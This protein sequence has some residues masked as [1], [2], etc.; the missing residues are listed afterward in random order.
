MKSIAIIGYKPHELNIF[1]EQDQKITVIQE[2]IK[3]QLVPLVEQELEW[4]VISG[5]PGVEM[6]AF[7]VVEQLKNDYDLKIAV[8][9]PFQNQDQVWN[10]EKQQ[11]YQTMLLKADF[12]QPL[13]QKSY[14]GPSQYQTR[15][16]WLLNKTDGCLIVYEDEYGG[17]PKYFHQLVLQYQEQKDYEMFQINAFDL[18]EIARDMQESGLLEYD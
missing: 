17:S 3:R 9:P 11:K 15:D 13:S 18:E 4:I 2:A 14:E 10:E 16:K 6:W 12:S 5:Q 1:N 8:I 7:D